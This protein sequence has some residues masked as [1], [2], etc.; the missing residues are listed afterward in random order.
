[1][2]ILQKINLLHLNQEA[3]HLV[4]Q[5]IFIKVIKPID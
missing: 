5:I 4:I 2:E 3:N 1:M